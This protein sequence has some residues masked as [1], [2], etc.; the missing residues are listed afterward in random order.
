MAEI[1]LGTSGWSYPEWVNAFYPAKDVNKLSFYSKV[2]RTAEIDSTFYSYPK[3]DLVFGWAKYTP[4]DF[5]FSAKLPSLITHEKKLNLEKGVEIDLRRFLDLIEPLHVRKKMGPVLIQLPPGF[6]Q[7]YER[8]ESFLAILPNEHR[9]AIEFR[10]FSWWNKETWILLTKY[11]V[12]NT[13]VDEPL[14]PPDVIVTADFSFIRWHGR[15]ERPWYDY[16]YSIE[17]LEP[18][19][20]K[21]RDA[22]QKTKEVFGYFNNHFHGYAVENCLQMM[23]MLDIITNE[24]DKIKEHVSNFLETGTIGIETYLSTIPSRVDISKMGFEDLLSTFISEE[25]LT[26]AKKIQDNEIKEL[27]IKDGT[28]TALIREYHVIVEE[29]GSIMHNCLDWAN[30]I[31]NK[32]FCKHLGKLFLVIPR[33]LAVEILRKLVLEKEDWHF[34]IYKD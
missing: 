1:R 21:V 12:S 27:T 14:L 30:C 15:G 6:K 19:I 7:D 11:G 18:W 20:P 22:C 13:I 33:D 34:K 31:L 16:R 32:S 28:I 26:R 29:N 3:K 8:L 4:P 10:H 17:E 9:F 25:K 24:Q 23:K 2:F 5:V